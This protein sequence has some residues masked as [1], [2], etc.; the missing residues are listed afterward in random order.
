[1]SDTDSK[2]SAAPRAKRGRPR[3]ASLDDRILTAALGVMADVGLR[4]CTIDAVAVRAEVPKSTIY[5][6]WPSKDEL[7]VATLERYVT[8]SQPIPDT[9]TLRGDLSEL[10]RAQ[11]RAYGSKQARPMVSFAFSVLAEGE[12]VPTATGQAVR[13]FATSRRSRYREVLE[14]AR[15][16]GEVR[17]TVDIEVAI[18]FLFGA[19]WARL[20]DLQ[21]IDDGF[22]DEV[23]DLACRALAPEGDTVSLGGRTARRG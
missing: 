11:I 17:D 4:G 10:F 19:V 22:A 20:A 14:R 21:P 12:A 13:R 5:R 18:S 23:V 15:E 16:R 2:P 1:M 7:Q 6:R 8:E 9:G 3:D